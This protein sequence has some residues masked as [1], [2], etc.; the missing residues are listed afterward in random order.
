MFDSGTCWG[1]GN[2]PVKPNQLCDSYAPEQ[3]AKQLATDDAVRDPGSLRARA[4]LIASSVAHHI[5]QA[6][7]RGKLQGIT[8]QRR[9]QE[10]GREAGNQAL[11]AAA[12]NHAGGAINAG[13]R[14][15]ALSVVAGSGTGQG[16]RA[17]IIGARYTSVLDKNSC[18]PCI[19]ADTGQL[20]ALDSPDWIP[21]P[22]PACLGGDR[23]R[24]IHVYQ[25][26]TEVGDQAQAIAAGL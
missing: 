22:N 8:D 5:W 12:G 10:L 20:L 18:G 26:S 6:V 23:C 19:A 14:A 11:K 17:Q 1:Y 15:G 25:L 16:A 7:H 13:R 24:C 3:Q 2:W 4:R 21:A 9:L